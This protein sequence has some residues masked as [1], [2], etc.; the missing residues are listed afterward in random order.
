MIHGIYSLYDNTIYEQ[1]SEKNTGYDSILDLSKL[2]VPSGSSSL[3]YN[4]RALLKFDLTT[5]SQSIAAGDIVSASYYLNLY[6][7]DAQEIQTNYTIE[8]YPIS[9]S[10]ES[11][12]GRYINIPETV[13]GSSWVNRN[14]S[15]VTATPWST[16]SYIA[17]TTASYLTI[18]GGGTWY[19]NYACTQ[20]H[21]Y[22]TTDLRI[23]VTTIVKDWIDGVIPNNGFVIKKSTTDEF[24]TTSFTTLKYFSTETN[25]VYQ[26]KLEV[27]WSDAVFSTGSL[28]Q[29]GANKSILVYPKNLKP[30]YKEASKIRLDIG[31]R[32]KYPI[33]TFATQSNYLTNNYLPSSSFFYS[34]QYADTQEVVIPFDN[35]YTKVSCDSSGNYIKL[36]L[37]GLQPERYYKLLFKVLNSGTEEYY[38]NNYIFKVTK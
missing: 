30:V 23:N 32:E 19:T 12:I 4:N 37:D 3:I 29:P 22:S 21:D 38:D 6:T 18:P 1:H 34:V 10:W 25:T 26:P 8:V 11:G 2:I 27:A 5:I 9:Q 36:W 33:I 24:N 31:V 17:N 15:G 7:A 16:G 14:N 13:I 28:T 35:T 20:S